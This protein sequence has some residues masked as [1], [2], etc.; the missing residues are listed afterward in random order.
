MERE[1]RGRK[2]KFL[3]DTGSSKNYIKDLKIFPLE[4]NVKS[5]VLVKSVHGENFVKRKAP[6]KIFNKV[7]DFFILPCLTTFDGIIGFEH[8]K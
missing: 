2:L 8:L 5:P 7:A 1:F 6:V 4:I 3:V